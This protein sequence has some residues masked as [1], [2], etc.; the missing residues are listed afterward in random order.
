M[1]KTIRDTVSLIDLVCPQALE[2]VGPLEV[3]WTVPLNWAMFRLYSE[4]SSA[5]QKINLFSHV[6]GEIER[7]LINSKSL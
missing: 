2:A 1:W 7:S 3:V 6:K 5:L 4:I